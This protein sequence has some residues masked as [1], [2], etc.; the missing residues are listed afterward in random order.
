MMRAGNDTMLDP[1]ERAIRRIQSVYAKWNRQTTAAQ[2]R[3]DWDAA[4]AG[5][6]VPVKCRSVSAGGTDAEWIVPADAPADKAI[7]Y[8]HGRVKSARCSRSGY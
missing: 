8:F 5:C 2:M 4:F 7:L 3:S 6:T 1:V